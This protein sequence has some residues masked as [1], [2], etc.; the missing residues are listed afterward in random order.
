MAKTKTKNKIPV[1]CKVCKYGWYFAGE[2]C[3][4]CK[5]L[6]NAKNENR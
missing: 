1:K 6:K 3:N 2:P 4:D 5:K